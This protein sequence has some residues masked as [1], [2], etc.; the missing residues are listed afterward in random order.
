[1]RDFLKATP[2]EMYSVLED[3]SWVIEGHRP[4]NRTAASTK[5]L[6]K[7]LHAVVYGSAEE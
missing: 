7:D 1:M 3:I 4:S 6:W 5:D 2:Q